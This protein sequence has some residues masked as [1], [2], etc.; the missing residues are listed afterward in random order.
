MPD[1]FHPADATN[2]YA[3]YD[4]KALFAFL[5]E[6]GVALPAKPEFAYSNLGVGLLGEALSERA[7]RSY[8]ALLHDDITGPL[9]MKDTSVALTASMRARFLPGHDS[10]HA[11][12]HAWDLNVLVGAGGIRSTAADMLAYVEAQL[13]PDH[14]PRSSTPAGK[15]LAA[16]LVASHVIHGEVGPGMHIALNWLRIDKTGMFWHG[17]ATA[18]YTSFVMF[19]PD[20]D[21]GIVVLSNTGVAGDRSFPEL[22]GEHIVARL[23]GTAALSLG[24]K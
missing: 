17:G 12:A 2:P 20:A 22:V 7:G 9:D 13:H 4:R 8:E 3:D 19:E 18:G 1:N 6:H 21:Y 11:P 16:A 15:T 23:A 10:E 5:A 14:L 24:P